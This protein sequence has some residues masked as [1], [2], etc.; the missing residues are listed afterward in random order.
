MSDGRK[1]NLLFIGLQ[2]VGCLRRDPLPLTVFSHPNIGYHDLAICRPDVQHSRAG[3]Y[4]GVT[5]DA[6]PLFSVE[7]ILC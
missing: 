7:I 5:E 1:A 3:Y 6:N 4:R 2:E